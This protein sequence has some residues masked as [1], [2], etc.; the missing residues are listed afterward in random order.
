M[1]KRPFVLLKVKIYQNKNKL[2]N[3]R[4]QLLKNLTKNFFFIDHTWNADL[5][6]MQLINKCNKG[7]LFYFV[8][9]IFIVNMCAS[10]L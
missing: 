7:F 8:V 3:Y 4:N 2:K 1:T 9:L 10:F 5:A 6:D